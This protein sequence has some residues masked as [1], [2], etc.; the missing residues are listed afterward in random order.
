MSPDSTLAVSTPAATVRS[1]GMTRATPSL[2]VV[3]LR[4]TR[5]N[6]A[7]DAGRP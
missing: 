2:G 3:V 4:R 1:S 7:P 6:P 5:V